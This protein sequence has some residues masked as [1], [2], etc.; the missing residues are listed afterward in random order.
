MALDGLLVVSSDCST[1]SGT[2]SNRP[3][4]FFRPWLWERLAM[5]PGWD[6]AQ[7]PQAEA[8]VGPCNVI[9]YTQ[10]ISHTDHLKHKACP[11]PVLEK[12]VASNLVQGSKMHSHPYHCHPHFVQA[13]TN[14]DTKIPDTLIFRAS[15]LN[16]DSHF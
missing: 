1:V 8:S 14:Q 10:G 4:Y 2:F 3:M 5:G 6:H 7:F 15:S 13:K 12:L 16:L 11:M 9:Y